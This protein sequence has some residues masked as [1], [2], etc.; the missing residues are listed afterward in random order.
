MVKY[1]KIAQEITNYI[2]D[3]KLKRHD[4]LPVIDE[5]VVDFNASKSTII[6]ALDILEAK[7]QIYQVQGS[8][9]FVRDVYIPGKINLNRPEGLS[10]TLLDET[11]VSRVVKVEL[12][13]PD[14]TI[15]EYLECEP[16]EDIYMVQRTRYIKGKIHSFE[17]SYLR[18]KYVRYMNEQIARGSI[19]TY[20]EDNLDLKPSFSNAFFQV[21][22]I[23]DEVG[24]FLNEPADN[25]GLELINQ[26]FLSNGAIFDYSIL[27]YSSKHAQFFVPSNFY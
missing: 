11:I 21:K 3:N 18:K 25:Y 1:K 15:Q 8:G 19:F 5:L 9:I 27:W 23:G 7:G 13:K 24:R 6:K 10:R 2:L 14:A 22:Q 20:L 4:K 12:I 26:F 16:N 17:T